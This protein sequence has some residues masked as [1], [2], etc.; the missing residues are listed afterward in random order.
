MGIAKRIHAAPNANRRGV[1]KFFP[2][3]ERSHD[4][5]QRIMVSF[6]PPP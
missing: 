1:R 2:T 6:D 4:P 5:K 3:V